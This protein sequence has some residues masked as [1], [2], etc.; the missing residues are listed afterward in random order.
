MCITIEETEQP[1][2]LPGSIATATGF[3]TIEDKVL[4]ANPQEPSSGNYCTA[5]ST[6]EPVAPIARVSKLV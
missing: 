6:S 4:D 1:S 5:E 2:D 3:T